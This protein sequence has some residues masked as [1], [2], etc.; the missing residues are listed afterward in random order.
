[1]APTPAATNA[2]V[3]A[4]AHTTNE[5]SFMTGISTERDALMAEPP[6]EEAI[7]P[8][9]ILNSLLKAIDNENDQQEDDENTTRQSNDGLFPHKS[10]PT[11]TLQHQQDKILRVGDFVFGSS[12]MDAAMSV[13]DNADKAVRCVR[14]VP[15]QRTAFLVEGSNN[16]RG[17]STYFCLPQQQFCTCR[18]YLERS[19]KEC[20]YSQNNSTVVCKHL[21]A[22]KL[23][24]YLGIE[25]AQETVSD[26]RYG[27][28]L[29]ERTVLAETGDRY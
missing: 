27:K 23:M 6:P 16:T 24:P 7:N 25:C 28:L 21:L 17:N 2:N 1:M 5:D 15:S 12:H 29:L 3:N 19:K 18:S 26:A 9:H 10:D 22:L 14:A 8:L 4:H 20:L 13:L 11:R